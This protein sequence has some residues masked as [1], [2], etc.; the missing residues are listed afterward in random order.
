MSESIYAR[1]AKH[2]NT[3]PISYPATKSGIEVRI[4]ERWF[5]PEEAEIALVMN[6]YPESVVVIS[7]RL[8]GAP[9]VLAAV[10]DAMSKKGLIFRIAKGDIRLYNIVP[11]AEGMYE[12]H[13]NTLTP[14]DVR[15]AHEY[16]PEYMERSWFGTKTTQHRVIPISKSIE[17]EM[18]V[19]PYNQAEAIIRQQKKICVTHCICRKEERMVGKGCDHPSETCM[20][21]GMGA[22]FYIE[23]GW[24][25]EVSQEEALKILHNAM[26]AGLVLQPGNGQKVWNLCMCCDCC[27]NILKVL[28]KMD[29][30]AAVA[31]TSFYAEVLEENCNGCGMCE[32]RCPMDAITVQESAE[33]NRDR[34]I[35]CGVCVGTCTFD[36]VRLHQKVEPDRYVPPEGVVEMQMKIATERG[37]V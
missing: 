9:E 24:G 18:E 15:M 6:G 29:K 4:L 27:C 19:M 35:G 16:M 2:L 13:L 33:I 11:L 37:L 30:P 12:F 3:L 32:T 17:S 14:E 25:R 36:A 21:F 5:T 34:C 28:K 7:E 8:K 31:H 23:N 20:A 26:D 22:Y 10:L 1:L